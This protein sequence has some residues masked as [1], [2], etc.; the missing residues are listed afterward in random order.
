MKRTALSIGLLLLLTPILPAEA[1]LYDT[2][3]TMVEQEEQTAEIAPD[4]A[5]YVS[6][7]LADRW[8]VTIEDVS[9]LA[10]N[11]WW[12]VCGR[13]SESDRGKSLTECMHMT[14]EV[15]AMLKQEI[16]V[17][18]LGHD[19]QAIASGYEVPVSDVPGRPV[20]LSADLRGIISLWSAGTGSIKGATGSLIRTK[21]VDLRAMSG[22]T[23]R[24]GGVLR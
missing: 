22:L 1:T 12:D 5:R 11:E 23:L 4:I 21:T 13:L 18:R 15:Q 3:R 24:V 8:G 9:Q 7:L 17:Q 19:L 6:A 10:R 20:R 14:Q 16:N 2:I